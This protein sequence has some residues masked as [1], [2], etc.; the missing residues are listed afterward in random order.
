MN[1]L[2]PVA[3]L[4]G[5]A[6]FVGLILTLVSRLLK[7]EKEFTVRVTNDGN[8]FTVGWNAN[9]AEA[10]K[11]A[12]YGI[13]TSCGGQG[14]CGTCRVRIIEGLDEPSP[15]QV[16]PLKGKLRKEGWVL[17]CQVQVQNDLVIELFAP[18]VSSWPAVA[19]ARAE[20]EAEAEAKAE[21]EAKA[22]AGAEV[23]AG[24]EG[25]GEGPG[26]P[27]DQPKSKPESEPKPKS[28]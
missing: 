19:K 20:A 8:E 2:I 11:A 6:V 15:A 14:V 1:F 28:G 21:T 27:P 10:L 12:G 7:V 18:L 26:A 5:L 4:G 23:K 9:L 24:G 17:S 25:E 22:G 13:M 16:G 3:T